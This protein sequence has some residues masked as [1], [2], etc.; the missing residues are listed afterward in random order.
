MIAECLR[1]L[2]KL[3]L[4]HRQALMTTAIFFG[5]SCVLFALTIVKSTW[6]T[7]TT[8][9]DVPGTYPRFALILGT[10]IH[11]LCTEAKAAVAFINS[12]ADE[13]LYSTYLTSQNDTDL[14]YNNTFRFIRLES[15]MHWW[16]EDYALGDEASLMT[17]L[18]VGVAS[19]MRAQII[20]NEIVY[21]PQT[22]RE[23]YMNLIKRVISLLETISQIYHDESDLLS[24]AKA[25]ALSSSA[26][27]VLEI[28]KYTITLN[29][30]ISGGGS[31]ST[32]QM[33][34][35]E[36][37]RYLLIYQTLTELFLLPTVTA[38]EKYKYMFATAT[39]YADNYVMEMFN[40]IT[41]N[42]DLPTNAAAGITESLDAILNIVDG[43]ADQ[44]SKAQ[45]SSHS[46]SLHSNLFIV[47]LAL[48]LSAFAIAAADF[49]F[50]RFY[51]SK[52]SREELY[53]LG[54]MHDLLIRVSEYAKAI[55]TFGLEP[56]PPP[57]CVVEERRVGIVEQQ[58][59]FLVGSLKAIAPF[60]PPLLFPYNFSVMAE[61]FS[62]VKDP[63][64]MVLTETPRSSLDDVKLILQN[65]QE[66]SSHFIP[67][68]I[69]TDIQEQVCDVA[70]LYVSLSVFH[71]LDS[72]EK[73]AL[74]VEHFQEIV[75]VIEECVYQHH[76][77]LTTVAFERAVAV[78]NIARKVPNFC[79]QAAAC[80]LALSSRLTKARMEK[81]V[82]RENFLV[83]LGVVGGTVNVGIFGNE[84]RKIL[85]FFGPPVLRG[86]FVAQTNGYHM[87]TVCCDDYVRDAIQKIYYCKPVELIPD[88]GCVHQILHKIS[89]DDSELEL[90]LA[91][92]CKAF[93]FFER[94]YYKSALK[95]FRAYTKQYGYDSSVE[96]IQALIVG[97]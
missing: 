75:A 67:M 70:L 39:T 12:P 40:Q 37:I 96:R 63:G 66:L 91:T 45:N 36:I 41:A 44:V 90:Q 32:L 11:E 61:E 35:K 93:E 25:S 19:R 8:I 71:E 69:K 9:R 21:S 10:L 34:E 86:M 20:Y 62:E 89:R 77:I 18:G 72:Q 68:A 84:E 78:W 85:S 31:A 48:V 5:L 38:K 87:T 23:H 7:S 81:R 58:L 52:A 94:Q 55:G 83:H 17:A 56:P 76:G 16:S 92:Y 50:K 15:A 42:R 4:H 29:S 74:S 59:Q 79:E 60:L 14:A 82:I 33:T 57:K 27:A 22:A 49:L 88:E 3:P 46:S 65:P 54:V 24:F 43:Y 26:Y 80:A 47:L 97:S 13:D 51:N 30:L 28:Q 73:R 95:A 64:T 6:S 2:K 1:R 53:H